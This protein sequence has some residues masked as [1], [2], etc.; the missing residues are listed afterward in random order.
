MSIENTSPTSNPVIDYTSIIIGKL[1]LGYSPIIGKFDLNYN[2]HSIPSQPPITIGFLGGGSTQFGTFH[3][4]LIT[5]K[6]KK[7]ITFSIKFTTNNILEKSYTVD[8]DNTDKIVLVNNFINTTKKS[9]IEIKHINLNK[10]HNVNMMFNY[11]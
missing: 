3:T 2:S 10:K 6:H 7:F 11:K 9:T 4:P 1:G 5:K 8:V